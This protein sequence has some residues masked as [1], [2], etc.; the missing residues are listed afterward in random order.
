MKA[1]GGGVAL[2]A[3][4]A[5]GAPGPLAGPPSPPGAHLAR[6]RAL[7]DNQWVNLGAPAA[8]PR[9]GRARGRTWG[10][11]AFMAAP[12]LRGAFLLG[13]GVHAFVKPDGHVMDD[14]WFYDLNAHRWLCLYPGL[15]I[16]NFTAR[17]KGKE[18]AIDS[19]GSLVD[20]DGQALPV[21]TLGHAWGYLAYDSDRRKLAFLG[22][23][24]LGRYFLGGEKVMNEGLELLEGQ[25]QGKTL[26]AFSPWF[27]DVASGR[28]ER[29]P[30]AGSPG[31]TRDM[32]PQLHYLPGR[33]QFIVAGASGVAFFDPAA[34][35]W[36]EVE[37]R[38]PTP[39][40]Y[41]SCGCLDSRRNRI[42]RTDGD[43]G[44]GRGLMAYDIA[45][46]T[47]IEL[48]PGGP[49]PAPSNTNAAFCE[50]DPDLDLVVLVYF[51]APT[52]GIHVY[53]PQENTWA[54]PLPL[55][56]AGPSFRYAANTFYDHELNA[57]LCHVAG[58]SEDDG[59]IWAYRYR[60]R[61]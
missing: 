47:W 40:G 13:E 33:R 36:S 9:W 14:L 19:A 35:R 24:G 56:T 8:D 17:V 53:N 23:D 50:Y 55:P 26:P 46:S 58:D 52:P 31:R 25:L 48:K 43:E 39:R 32:F 10:A 1:W 44:A 59:V 61:D 41:D 18:L 60:P 12:D 45:S 29:A 21:H 49:A 16:S 20:R 7:G 6:V 2:L 54:K 3:A 38:G 5:F 15:D 37:P 4:A 34:G 11:K 42:Y 57:F 51:R 30:A 28:F 22:N 27:Y